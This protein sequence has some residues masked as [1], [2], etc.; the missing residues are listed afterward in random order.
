MRA[1]M[2]H[3]FE[4]ET[5]VRWWLPNDEGFSPVLQRVRAFADE[6]SHSPATAQAQRSHSSASGDMTDFF[7]SLVD[8]R[9]HD[10]RVE[11]P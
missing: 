2:A 5:V 6:R 1:Q 3:M 8:L 11:S 9:L 10:P 4:D 7:D